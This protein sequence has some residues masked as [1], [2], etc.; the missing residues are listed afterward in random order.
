M[1]ATSAEYAIVIE[2]TDNNYA[3][4]VPDLPGCIATGE[5]EADVIRLLREGAAIYVRELRRRGQ[6]VPGP[7]TR[8]STVPVEA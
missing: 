8:T 6:P 2:R 3:G 5:T 1:T 7:T 4:Y